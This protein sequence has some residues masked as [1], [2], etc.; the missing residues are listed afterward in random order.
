MKN[1]KFL[2]LSKE[3][4]SKLSSF[5]DQK[6]VDN[7]IVKEGLDSKEGIYNGFNYRQVPVGGR[8]GNISVSRALNDTA[9]L[10]L[11]EIIYNSCDAI[12]INES[13]IRGLSPSDADNTPSSPEEAMDKWFGIDYSKLGRSATNQRSRIMTRFDDTSK[14]GEFSVTVMDRGEGQTPKNMPNTL[15]S[16]SD[17]NK[18][19]TFFTLGRHNMGSLGWTSHL[20]GKAYRLITSKQ[21]PAISSGNDETENLV[22]FSLSRILNLDEFSSRG[23]EA[24]KS[25]M[26]VYYQFEVDGKWCVPMFEGSL[27]AV[28]AKDAEREGMSQFYNADYGTVVKGYNLDLRRGLSKVSH[29]LPNQIKDSK[30]ALTRING[31]LKFIL[32]R[33]PTP[34]K[35]YMPNFRPS[36]GG[37]TGMVLGLSDA[38]T[39]T[40]YE[41]VGTINGLGG[42]I[43]VKVFYLNNK[44]TMMNH[45]GVVYKVCSMLIVEPRNVFNSSLYRMSSISDKII[46]SVDLRDL[47][48]RVQNSL[49]QTG[50]EAFRQTPDF[51]KLREKISASVRSLP[52]IQEM[53]RSARTEALGQAND[54]IP[55][56]EEILKHQNKPK[57]TPNKSEN[58]QN[59]CEEKSKNLQNILSLVE[60]N[61]GNFVSVPNKDDPRDLILSKMISSNSKHFVI[62]FSTDAKKS[63]YKKN[64]INT[65]ISFSKSKDG[66]FEKQDNEF[67][68]TKQENGLISYLITQNDDFRGST[69]YVKININLEKSDVNWEFVVPC[70]ANVTDKQKKEIS[71][72]LAK[73][74][75]NSPRAKGVSK[76]CDIDIVPIRNAKECEN[77]YIHTDGDSEVVM[78]KNDAVGYVINDVRTFGINLSEPLFT[79]WKKSQS[80]DYDDHVLEQEYLASWRSDLRAL[81]YQTQKEEREEGCGKDV[82]VKTINDIH[83][84][85][86]SKFVAL[87]EIGVKKKLE[88]RSK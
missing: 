19:S 75:K 62:D 23:F 79:K 76:K 28:N 53:L 26:I 84:S 43:S 1:K 87:F 6:D 35:T 41:E 64:P 12:L 82:N 4:H 50:R 18:L 29:L 80:E 13:K 2:Q 38:L 77:F 48:L 85:S 34:M 5:S 42:S 59:V 8:K 81:E 45:S 88:S 25:D 71:T 15:F 30:Q 46:V 52:K 17:S 68:I 63:S 78:S 39:T 37:N 70:L 49:L 51:L 7:F 73:R 14:S 67:F 33:L 40:P 32:S 86:F 66:E 36:N 3:L 69:F 22:G 9:F 61:D 21:N 44:E 54:Y 31:V 83:P 24:Q 55:A 58:F 60:I 10:A 47:P 72:K 65:S 27:S 16:L 57:S 56:L 20:M 74:G 11:A